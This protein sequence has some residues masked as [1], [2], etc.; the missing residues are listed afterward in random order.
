MGIALAAIGCAKD[1]GVA[2]MSGDNTLTITSNIASRVASEQWEKSDEIGVYMTSSSFGDEGENVLYTTTSG[3]GNFASDNPLYYPSSGTVSILAYY[4]F[5]N[6][7]NLTAYPLDSSK[8]VDL[9]LATKSGVAA[10]FSA[11]E[12]SF[13]HLLSKLSLTIEAGTG[14]TLA[15]LDNLVVTISGIGTKTDD[16][17]IADSTAE[18]IFSEYSSLTLATT[19]TKNS[20]ETAITAISSSAIVIPQG[21]SG[22]VLYFA[23]EDYGTFS[24]T[25][26]TSAFTAGDEYKYTA[27]INRSGVDITSANI[28]IWNDGEISSGVADIVDIEYKTDTYYIN[29]AKGLAAF[30]DLVNGG[31]NTQSAMFVG[32]ESSEFGTA[33]SD[34]TGKLTRDIDLGD[35]Y[36]KDINGSEVSWIPIGRASDYVFNGTFDG[37]GHCVSGLYINSGSKLGLFGYLDESGLVYNVGVSGE[38]TTSSSEVGGIVS[39]NKGWV[40]N[41]YSEVTI[42]GG[43]NSGGIAG[44]N[45]GNVVNCYNRGDVEGTNNVGGVIGQNIAGGYVGYCYSV[46]G[47]DGDT[48]VGGIVGWN[49]T[50][51]PVD[52]PTIKGCFSLD[53]TPYSIGQLGYAASTGPYDGN[54]YDE[55]YLKSTVFATIIENGA[56]TYNKNEDDAHDVAPIAACAWRDN[57]THNYPTLDI[58]KNADEIDWIYDIVYNSGTYEIYS[59]KGLEYF[60]ALVNGTTLPASATADTEGGVVTSGGDAYFVDLGGLP[61]PGINGSILIDKDSEIALDGTWTPIG[62]Y[63][64]SNTP[65]YT[66]TFAGN[67]RK[68]TGL[69]TD[70]SKNYQGLFGYVDN[71]TISGIYICEGSVKG[72]DYVGGVVGYAN[73]SSTISGCYNTSDVDGDDVTGSG[74]YV[75][76]VVGYANN[77]S[78]ISGCYNTS[79]VKGDNDTNSGS[80]VGGVVG[81]ADSSTVSGCY[82]TGDVNGRIYKVGGVVGCAY[83]STISGCYNDGGSISGGSSGYVGG[84]VGQANYSSTVS[85]CYNTG[86]ITGKQDYVGGVVGDIVD[87]SSSVTSCYSCGAVSSEISTTYIGGVVGYNNDSGT[88]SYCYYDYSTIGTTNTVPTTAVGGYPSATTDTDN[89]KGL[90][91]ENMQEEDVVNDLND[92]AYIYNQTANAKATIGA[93][94]YNSGNQYPTIDASATPIMSGIDIA[95]IN[96]TYDIFTAK[97][98]TAFADLVNGNTISSSA[99]TYG[100]GFSSSNTGINGKLMD[101]INLNGNSW[102]PIG[103]ASHAYT[104]TFNGKGFEV[105]NISIDAS[106][107][108]YQGLFG[109][110]SGATIKYLG[111]TGGSITGE[112]YVG[113]IVGYAISS[114]TITA[115]YNSNAVT[116]SSNVGGIVGYVANSS[117]TYC[118]SYGTVSGSSSSNVGGVVGCNI[119]STI[120]SCYYDTVTVGSTDNPS[121]AVGGTD[122][123]DDIAS[124]YAGLTTDEMTDETLYDYLNTASPDTWTAV[125]GSYPTFS[126]QVSGY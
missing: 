40:M 111:V 19:I 75:G 21:L 46:G 116:G 86:D 45:A 82:N 49:Y 6:G 80:Y 70:S 125:T 100:D 37:D 55:A 62:N 63:S 84:V 78:T 30:R 120:T 44:Y 61:Q 97:G 29:S 123:S 74:D 47:I 126:W 39:W 8:Q 15:D 87:S 64:D 22:A 20:D 121:T 18:V 51:S 89:V 101:N 109:Y 106:S 50:T 124:G 31:T 67:N 83:S 2:T 36:G 57:S 81:Y 54:V 35:I 110:I 99:V 119:S 73:N 112:D 32:F 7:V 95:Y 68:I 53:N 58:G 72:G 12:L 102:T 114:S 25:L 11:V 41:S 13:N 43:T 17:N 71:A 122:D 76:G 113:G 56:F 69:S 34:I 66:G 14:L 28:D 38:V 88:I 79:D 3:D 1:A 115:C 48:R 118:Y 16:F 24:A 104:G 107:S 42:S 26:T 27:T 77:S 108:D 60:A 65:K 23:T 5:V 98:L 59:A 92:G 103:D 93:W 9:L 85:G 33:H 52:A 117:V 90:S 96:N 105:Q 4:P 10:S 94:V 91:T